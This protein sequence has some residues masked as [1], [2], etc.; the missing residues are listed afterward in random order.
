MLIATA[1]SASRP[2]NLLFLSLNHR[3]QV[4]LLEPEQVSNRSLFTKCRIQWSHADSFARV[5]GELTAAADP[6]RGLEF[7]IR[8][9][10]EGKRYFVRASFG[11]PKGFG[12]FS[13]ST[14]K[15][16]VP[17][18]WRSSLDGAEARVPRI[19]SHQLD[20]C[21]RTYEVTNLNELGANIF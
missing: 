7:K 6:A 18:S 15:S 20:V 14:P 12:P 16:V 11:N 17:S 19:T 2:D 4:R 5:E 8:A 1:L 10:A 3:R 9:L 13:A 21:Q